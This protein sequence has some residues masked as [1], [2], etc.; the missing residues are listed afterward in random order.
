VLHKFLYTPKATA[1]EINNFLR[2]VSLLI[3]LLCFYQLLAFISG[4]L[5]FM[6]DV[7]DYGNSE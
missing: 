2:P 7:I 1:G 5:S 3:M 4:E 6:R